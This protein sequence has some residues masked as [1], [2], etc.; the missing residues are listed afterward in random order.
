VAGEV[1]IKGISKADTFIVV[2]DMRADLLECRL[3]RSCTRRTGVTG[4]DAVEFSGSFKLKPLRAYIDF[5]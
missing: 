2:G 3:L 1:N 4:K 5:S